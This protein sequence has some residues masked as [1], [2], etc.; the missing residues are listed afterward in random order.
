MS[1]KLFLLI[2][3]VA[4]LA[5]PMSALAQPAPAD[6]PDVSP[7][8]TEFRISV[9]DEDD[10]NS[11]GHNTSLHALSMDNDGDAVVLLFDTM[12]EW[13]IQARLYDKNGQP[14]GPQFIV[15]EYGLGD[16]RGADVAMDADGDFVVVWEGIFAR[17]F[18]ASGAP[19][20]P[21]FELDA[22]AAETGEIAVAADD[23]G[24]FTA[25]WIEQNW[26][27]TTNTVIARR[28]WADGSP[29]GAAIVVAPPVNYSTDD[30]HYDSPDVAMDADGDFVVSWGWST[31]D[32]FGSSIQRYSA[33]GTAQ[34]APILLPGSSD[35]RL[36]S[37][38]A[39]NF[40]AVWIAPDQS[41][42]GVFARRFLANGAP[43]GPQFQVNTGTDYGQN[44]HSVAM[45]A[46]GEMYIAWTWDYREQPGELEAGRDVYGR[47]Y[48]ANGEPLGDQFR[49]NS[50]SPGFPSGPHVAIDDQ[51]DFLAAWD[52][53]NQDGGNDGVYGQYGYPTTPNI[54]IL[55][56]L[57]G[58]GRVRGLNYSRGDILKYDPAAN[59]WAMFWDASDHGVSTANV[60]DFEL[61]DDG[62]LLL[63]FKTAVTLPGAG[64]VQPH[65]I[66][67]YDAATAT[68]SL[69]FD[70]SDVGLTT[71]GERLDALGMEADGSLLLSTVASFAVPGLTGVDEYTIRFQP[72]SLGANTVGSWTWVLWGVNPKD[73]WALWVD[74]V[75]PDPYYY[76]TFEQPIWVDSGDVRIP[77]GGIL[78]CRP[79]YPQGMPFSYSYCLEELYWSAAA[80]GLSATAKIDGLELLTR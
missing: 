56:S 64:K 70:G 26:S 41:E 73:L 7:L 54:P 28:F 3:I 49:I 59:Q 78:R 65:D 60:G 1:R 35:T 77:N 38:S 67:R 8:G 61:L 80:A 19:K 66:A 74:T 45:N 5:L 76:M 48:A 31:P 75:S 43:N 52:T 79:V 36:A 40:V 42:S 21:A 9:A 12:S 32:A 57:L 47:R 55:I 20:G 23:A 16:L 62:D 29:R 69:Y 39:C 34:G 58:N 18:N 44:D 17:L 11:L 2:L 63:V 72:T 25:V 46:S 14:K 24:N 37:D 30:S 71:Q 33:A 50:Y 53:M 13:T 15:A 10:L 6:P 68:Y 27:A 4:A 51:G 22:A